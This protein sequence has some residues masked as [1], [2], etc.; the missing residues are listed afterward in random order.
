MTPERDKSPLMSART[1]E[2]VSEAPKKQR[3]T[4]SEKAAN[5]ILACNYDEIPELAQ[6]LA[7]RSRG[8]GLDLRVHL[9]RA[10]KDLLG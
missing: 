6:M 4:R 9:D 1:P 5:A 3:R 2:P 8:L 10:L 7:E